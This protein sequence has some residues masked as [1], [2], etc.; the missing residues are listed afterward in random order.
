M[1]EKTKEEQ[2]T[3]AEL[4]LVVQVIRRGLT[5]GDKLDRYEERMLSMAAAIKE[6]AR[7]LKEANRIGQEIVRHYQ[8]TIAPERKQPLSATDYLERSKWLQE[9]SDELKAL[10]N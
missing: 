3:D 5:V 7:R 8:R 6:C 10:L 1:S 2:A 4:E 9:K